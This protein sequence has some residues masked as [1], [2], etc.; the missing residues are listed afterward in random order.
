MSSIIPGKVHRI[1]MG[2]QQIYPA[3][4][5][6]TD[7]VALV[8]A[9]LADLRDAGQLSDYL[10]DHNDPRG[11]LLRRR[12]KRWQARRAKAEA[13]DLKWTLEERGGGYYTVIRK[14]IT[15]FGG[16]FQEVQEKMGNR[17]NVDR[18]FTKYIRRRFRDAFA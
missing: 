12:W 7:L 13:E 6:V 17:I 14:I 5:L 11:V 18:S 8:R 4:P 2:G 3:A 9:S 1:T 15:F 10:E 16:T